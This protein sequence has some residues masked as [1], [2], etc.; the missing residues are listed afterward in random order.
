MDETLRKTLTRPINIG[1]AFSVFT[2]ILYE[3][4]IYDYPVPN[5]IEFYFFLLAANLCMYA[6]F[7]N[8][9]NSY[10]ECVKDQSYNLG[11]IV[12]ILFWVALLASIPQFMIFT[13]VRTFSISEIMVKMYVAYEDALD[14]YMDKQNLDNAT[15]IWMYINW[16]VV[17]TGPLSWAY[18]ILAMLYWKE[19]SLFKKIGTTFIWFLFL[20]QYITNGTNVGVFL[21]FISFGVIYFVKKDSRNITEKKYSW[22]GAIVVGA[23]V[24]ITLASYFSMTMGSRIGDQIDGD[25]PVDE[26]N[27]FWIITPEPM[28]N[29]LA[30]FT[31]YLASAYNALALSFSV[32]FDTT[33]GVGHSSFLLNNFDLRHEYLWPKTYIIKLDEAFQWDWYAN[34]HTP[35]VWLANDFSFWGVPFILFF[36][37]SFFGY[38]WRKYKETGDV[39]SFLVFMLYVEFMSFISA[40][41][42]VF[43]QPDT[44]MAFWILLVLNYTTRNIRWIYNLDE[45]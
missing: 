27:L 16:L 19:L 40:N 3:F 1:I 11:R 13:G 24:L 38:S 2:I 12:T 29:L 41:N 44:M 6:G 36:L 21:F 43:Q 33:F 26:D 25:I 15:G 39:V 28:R 17:L 45:I 23:L 35:Y 5:R 4:G 37:F 22:I 34:W 14:L 42:I 7:I 20:S 31:R 10:E 30:Y 8:G 32:P 9:M 18:R